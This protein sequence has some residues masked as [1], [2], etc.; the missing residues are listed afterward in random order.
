MW[1]ER[2]QRQICSQKTKK[3]KEN[4]IKINCICSNCGK[5]YHKDAD[6]W[7][8]EENAIKRLKNMKNKKKGEGAGVGFY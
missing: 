7:N 5:K 8:R 6:C 1:E 3:A 4:E 2:A